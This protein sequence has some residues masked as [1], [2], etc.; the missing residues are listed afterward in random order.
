MALVLHVHHG[1]G[2]PMHTHTPRKY[3]QNALPRPGNLTPS[4]AGYLD[5]RPQSRLHG[6]EGQRLSPSLGAARETLV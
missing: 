1:S 6:Q 3:E 5:P 2:R 4:L